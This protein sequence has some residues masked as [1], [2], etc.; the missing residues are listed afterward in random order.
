MPY[1]PQFSQREAAIV[2]RIA[3]GM[4]KPM[5]K[6]LSSIIAVAVRC[7]DPKPICEACKD[8]SFC[9][10]CPFRESPTLLTHSGDGP[11]CGEAMEAL[12]DP[13]ESVPKPDVLGEHP[14]QTGNAVTVKITE[15]NIKEENAMDII[16]MRKEPHL[17]ASGISDYLT[18]GFLYK[19]R[20]IDKVKPEFTS[21]ALVFGSTIHATLAKFHE[22]KLIGEKLSLNDLLAV[23]KTHWEKAAKVRE[24]IRYDPGKDFKTLL[25]EG[26]ALLTT[27]YRNLV[28][29]EFKV[30]AIEQ[31]FRFTVGN[32]PVIGV[33]DL[34]E[35][36]ES[37]TVI[38]TDFKT[39]SRAYSA[40]EIDSNMQL[41][42]YYL[43]ARANG[44]HD[45]HILLRIDSLIKTKTPKFQQYYTSRCELDERRVTKKILAVWDGIQKGVFIP[46]DGNWK[47]KGC[48]YK[49]HCDDFL[50][51]EEAA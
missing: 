47:C 24:D 1:T 42:I 22:H 35:E 19:L 17:S 18:C 7:A 14:L 49:S 33:T 2:R 38:I 11:N 28:Q 31:P 26:Q 15:S 50:Q 46:N 9:P 37:G 12:G 40:D 39:T 34:I 44:Y 51:S 48:E 27:Y 36:D 43:G 29:D 5:T 25:G 21:D 8:R 10:E 13:D 16:E 32:V 6:A 4:R 30:I 41:S 23:F 45:R 20:R 3:W